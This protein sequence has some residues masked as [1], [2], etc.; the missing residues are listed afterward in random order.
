MHTRIWPVALNLAFAACGDDGG[1]SLGQL[2]RLELTPP[3]IVFT[4]DDAPPG[5]ALTLDLL[6]RN[7]GDGPLALHAIALEPDPALAIPRL[8]DPIPP[9]SPGAA[10]R[11]PITWTRLDDRLVHATLTITSSDPER[12]QVIVP[13]TV[14]RG[15][16]FLVP[17]PAHVLIGDAPSATL[18]LL[19]TGDAPATIER[20]RFS[21]GSGYR[22]HIDA[23]QTLDDDGLERALDPPLVLPSGTSAAITLAADPLAG[24][25]SELVFYGDATNTVAGLH[26][27]VE[28]DVQ[29]P[30]V[31]VR[32]PAVDFGARAPD[33][34]TTLPI[35]IE[36]CGDDALEIVSIALADAQAAA[37]PALAALGVTSPSSER[38]ALAQPLP[39]RLEAGAITTVALTYRAASTPS[40]D[41]GDLVVRT[42]SRVPIVVVPITAATAPDPID[43]PPTGI[44]GCEWTG[45]EVR[46]HH[47]RLGLTA[48]DAWEGWLDGLPIARPPGPH[49]WKDT[50]WHELT[51]RSG[52]HT[53]TL[54]AWDLHAVTSGII[55][56]IEIDGVPRWV[57]GD[58]KPEWHVTGPDVP[59]AGWHAVDFDDAAWTSPAACANTQPWAGLPYDLHALGAR[60]VWWNPS[61]RDLSNAYFRLVFTVD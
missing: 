51:L 18:T 61:C 38:L 57:S 33:T 12:P 42:R 4:L 55:A 60:W 52:C 25:T 47:V 41:R 5:G 34:T 6:V 17:T 46:D 36:S 28:R 50:S 58:D 14:E 45:G 32:P 37:D 44:P 59:P 9:L 39:S 53:L 40:T 2:G 35:E 19:N 10:R 7:T 1:F 21:G 11:V 27:P 23:T 30:C 16:G 15:R 54:H 13:I 24:G 49:H 31:L 26:V 3:R 22:A 56:A 43:P 20:V 8:P 29:G 48:D